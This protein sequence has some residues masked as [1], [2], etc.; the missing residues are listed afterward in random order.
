M[1]IGRNRLLMIV[2]LCLAILSG[3]GD[4]PQSVHEVVGHLFVGDQPAENASIAFHPVDP[5]LS[6]ACPVGITAADGSFRLTTYK[7]G[8]GAPA[9]EYIVTVIWP[10]ETK[11]VDEC[12]CPSLEDHDRLR[13]VYAD[14]NSSPIRATIAPGRN[15][16][17]VQAFDVAAV[18]KELA[19][20]GT[21][22]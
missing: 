16:V 22:E 2:S 14:R 7:R 8:D 13:G 10:D 17:P 1:N 19:D 3:C 21:E 15:D 20:R 5:S 9:G 18:L 4:D 11:P 6:R 12:D